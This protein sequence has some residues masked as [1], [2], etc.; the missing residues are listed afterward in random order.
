MTHHAARPRLLSDSDIE[1]YADAALHAVRLASLVCRD[2]QQDAFSAGRAGA[3]TKGDDSPV[4]FADFA[5]QAVVA[6]TLRERL[7]HVTLVGEEGSDYLRDP[8]HA[9]ALE[10][11]T[12]ATSHVWSS[13]D[14]AALLEAVDLGAADPPI[15]GSG[16]WTLDP[17][18]GTKG[19]VR[20]EQYSVC[21]AYI[22][23]GEPIIAALGCPNLPASFDAPFDARDPAG[24]V[25]L[26]VK[27]G[28]V[29]VA[30]ATQPG[31]NP[32]PLHVAMRDLS[33]PARSCRSVDA[34]HSDHDAATQVLRA[35]GAGGE[36]L[37]LDSQCKYAVVAR[38]QAEVYLRLPR[39]AGAYVERIW[40]HAPGA[41]IA[42]ET[43]CVVT[44]VLGRPLD[45][46]KGRGL[47]AN[48]GVLCC[49][50]EFHQPILRAIREFFSA[51][52]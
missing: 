16:F 34:S 14:E 32:R 49:R 35:A 5:S 43:G 50:T 29:R 13:V 51:R 15:D 20:G 7:A 22:L 9:T 17:I 44:D 30:D 45:F 3:I 27:G 40:D 38:G 46:S 8:E 10:R 24:Q 2:A 23:D 41:L 52:S 47:D 21:L 33:A 19:F 11:A 39:R 37:R 12:R 48:R 6:H 1:T 18:D 4:T 31:H 36:P 42:Q 25:F 26:A 28:G